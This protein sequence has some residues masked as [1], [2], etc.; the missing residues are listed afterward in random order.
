MAPR[1]RRPPSPA[2]LTGIQVSYLREIRK[3][4]RFAHGLVK[5]RLKPLLPELIDRA[6]THR[7]D[8]LHED[9]SPSG[10]AVNVINRMR[11]AVDSKFTAARLADTV[12][13]IADQTQ[14]HQRRQLER[15]AAAMGVPLGKLGRV[16]ARSAQFVAEGVSLIQSIPRNYFDQVEKT[17][18]KGIRD[19][20]RHTTVAADIEERFNVSE[21]RAR[22]IARDQVSK[23]NGEVNQ[24]RQEAMGV[25]RYVWR[26]VQDNRVRQDHA[27]REGQIYSWDDPPGD[28]DDPGTGG[29]PGQAIQCR[30]WSEP[31]FPALEE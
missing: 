24:V 14:A 30:C 3:V 10:R 13:K 17:V 19:G 25:E 20:E 1:R 8:S 22:L 9:A 16:A 26:T 18:L 2:P 12:R 6:A 29:H 5:A 15:Q 4:T 23:F 31:I 28:P 11:K 21:S 27:D 7:G